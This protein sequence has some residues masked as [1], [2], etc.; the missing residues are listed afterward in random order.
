MYQRNLKTFLKHLNNNKLYAL[1][2]VFGFAIS[3]TFVILLSVYIKNEMAVNA[4]Q[5]KAEH[6]YRLTNEEY[7]GFAPP[8]GAWLQSE[9]PEIES[10]T[11]IFENSSIAA[12]DQG[13]KIGFNYLMVDSTFFNIFTFNLIEGNKESAL[14]TKNSVVLTKEFAHKLFGTESPIGKQI[15]VNKNVTCIVT[16][17][18]EDISTHSNFNKCDGIVNFRCLADIWGSKQLLTS[19][20]NNSFGLY[21]L[22][23]PNTNLALK[24]PIV[25]SMFKKDFWM[26]QDDRFKTVVFEPFAET[27]FS[28]IPGIAIKQNSKILLTIL[29]AIVMLILVL[30]II[31]YMNLTIAQSGLR[32]METAI[33]KLMGSSKRRLVGQLINESV[34]LCFFSFFI[35]VILSFLIEPIFGKLLNTEMHLSEVI[36]LKI[37]G[38]SVFYIFLIG[39][40]SGIVPALIIAKLNA[41]EVIKGGFRRKSKGVYSRILI[42]FQYTIVIVLLIA[43][44][45]ISKQTS[46]MKNHSLGFNTENIVWFDYVIS[47]KYND[48]LRSEL[49]KIPGVKNV[50]FIAGSPI[51]G[52]NNQSFK[53]NDKPVSFQEFIVDSAFFSMMNMTIRPTGTAYSK[54][55]IYLN[56]KAVKELDLGILPKTFKRY[57]K[58]F[59]VLGIIDDFNFGSLHEKISPA[60]ILQ[61]DTSHYPWN[62]FVQIEGANQLAT[63]ENIKKSYSDFSEGLPFECGF[64]ND[65]ISEWYTK[66]ERTSKIV[67]YFSLLTIVIAS[68][69]IFAMSIF[70]I[71]QKNKE[72]GIRKVNGAKV[73]EIIQLLNYNFILWVL[74]AFIL[75]CP[76]AYYVMNK[77]LQNFAYKTTLSWWIF[78]LAGLLTLIIAIITVSWQTFKAARRNP[79]EALRYE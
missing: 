55:G 37:I 43:T 23:K 40:I 8:V 47:P 48:G 9:I 27:Y 4:S 75:A 19:L 12:N 24:A 16:G 38:I 20:G 54:G 2:T 60:M 1:V 70:Y 29:S 15:F 34:L 25:L 14:K 7:A 32:V 21:F 36:T 30:A 22:A 69:G 57:S 42:G 73:H 6:I 77:W 74:I 72:I 51:D 31:N 39:L 3:L 11:R 35:A 45:V 58:E 5:K 53:Y 49:L 64:I 56:Q 65:A 52:G 41:I 28:N 46:F 10:Y 71:Q 62:I 18:V 26:Y 17:I 13:T 68:M 50:S 61:M 66:E 76:L 44:I 79:I 78:A 67:G 59:P 63:L 33:K